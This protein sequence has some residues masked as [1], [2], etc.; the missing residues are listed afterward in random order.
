MFLM[1]LESW[2]FIEK[3]F[4]HGTFYSENV[5]QFKNE[6][7]IV[8]T[9]WPSCITAT[10][11]EGGLYCSKLLP[12]WTDNRLVPSEKLCCTLYKVPKV[13]GSFSLFVNKIETSTF[14]GVELLGGDG[15]IEP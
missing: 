6:V 9:F 15:G 10:K 1:T 7:G 12:A 3:N 11:L 13:T 5:I 2:N 8:D 4:L 14:C